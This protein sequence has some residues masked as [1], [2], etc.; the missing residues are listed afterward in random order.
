MGK[1]R[2]RI[3][4]GALGATGGMA[5][6]IGSTGICGGG[7]CSTCLRCAGLGVVLAALS[8]IKN[9]KGGRYYGLAEK[10]Y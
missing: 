10:R 3:T 4:F 7:A 1:M 2:N 9:K 8:I 6:L 5:A